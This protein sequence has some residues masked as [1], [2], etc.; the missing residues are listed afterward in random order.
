[1]LRSVGVGVGVR[2]GTLAFLVRRLSVGPHRRPEKA[3]VDTAD[4]K[5]LS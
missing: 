5:G 2:D 4:K 1:M 3:A